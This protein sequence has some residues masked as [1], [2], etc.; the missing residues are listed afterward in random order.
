MAYIEVGEEKIDPGT[1][2]EIER[3]FEE[4]RILGI[5]VFQD[6]KHVVQATVTGGSAIVLYLDHK[7]AAAQKPAGQVD[8]DAALKIL[9]TYLNDGSLDSDFTWNVAH[10]PTVQTGNGCRGAAALLA[11]TFTLSVA[12]IAYSFT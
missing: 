7:K 6:A 9:K 5:A 1:D 11:V 8:R 4:K 2:A 3:L 10:L 12:L